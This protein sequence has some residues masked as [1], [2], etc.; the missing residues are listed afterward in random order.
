MG[1]NCCTLYNHVSTPNTNSCAGIGF[2]SNMTNMAMQVSANSYHPGGVEVMMGDG[3]VRFTA[4]TVDLS[5]WRALGTR[6]GRES[7]ELP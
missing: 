3:S 4:N 1:E 2:G 7:V 6:N 5:T